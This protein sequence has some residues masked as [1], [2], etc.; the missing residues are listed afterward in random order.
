MPPKKIIPWE[1][2]PASQSPNLPYKKS[3][4]RKSP[5]QK[6]KM[7][8]KSIVP[9]SKW[10]IFPAIESPNR[11]GAKRQYDPHKPW[12]WLIQLT[13]RER[14]DI[15]DYVYDRPVED[16]NV[17]KVQKI[18]KLRSRTKEFIMFVLCARLEQIDKRDLF[19]KIK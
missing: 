1:P 19:L 18:L 2:F 7:I 11:P 14:F 3:P 17:E 9:K 15:L 6:K 4:K 5:R 12:N 16:L 8:I 13:K 10:D